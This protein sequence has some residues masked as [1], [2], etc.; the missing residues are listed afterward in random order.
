MKMSLIIAVIYTTFKSLN[1]K[2]EKK[3]RP[4]WVRTHELYGTGTGNW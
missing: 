2:P 3:F 1:L 4:E